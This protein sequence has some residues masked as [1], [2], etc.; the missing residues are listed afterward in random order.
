MDRARSF[1]GTKIVAY[2]KNWVYFTQTFGLTIVDYVEPKPG[3]PPSARH[4]SRIM[5]LIRQEQIRV[6]IVADYFEKGT[7]KRIE[8]KTGAK[9]VFLTL[10]VGGDEGVDDYFSL[11]DT[12]IGRIEEALGVSAS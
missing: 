2:H 1:Y 8:E 11:I 10:D 12:W 3:I 6:M 4:V 7:P 5:D 9:A